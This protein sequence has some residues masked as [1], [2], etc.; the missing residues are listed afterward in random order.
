MKPNISNTDDEDEKILKELK[1]YDTEDH[2]L[3]YF[4]SIKDNF[5]EYDS[6]NDSE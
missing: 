1:E 6:S 3:N 5:E 2:T 4:I